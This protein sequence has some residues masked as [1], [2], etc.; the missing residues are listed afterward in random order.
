MSNE[1]M[2][3][4]EASDLLGSDTRPLSSQ[5]MAALRKV[6]NLL[7]IKPVKVRGGQSYLYLRKD[8]EAYLAT[9]N[10]KGGRPKA[11]PAEQKR[12]WRARLVAELLEELLRLEGT[13]YLWLCDVIRFRQVGLFQNLGDVD[14]ALQ[15]DFMDIHVHQRFRILAELPTRSPKLLE[16][17][18]AY[19][20]K[21]GLLPRDRAQWFR[22][23]R[24]AV[25]PAIKG[26]RIPPGRGG[27]R[28]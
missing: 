10:K 13:S 27:I 12:E 25:G 7:R 19:A 1:W 4:G 6:P 22:F 23:I 20:S 24:G 9:R 2:T 28:L 14:K 17:A 11:Q 21:D 26:E 16:L 15:S 5:R 3:Q 18:Q 8:V